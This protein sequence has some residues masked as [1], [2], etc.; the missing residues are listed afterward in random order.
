MKYL[1]WIL[2]FFKQ[3]K[4]NI[5][6]LFWVTF[7][8]PLFF[9]QSTNLDNNKIIY[10]IFYSLV[11]TIQIY[12]FSLLTYGVYKRI[13]FIL[14]FLVFFLPSIVV[15]SAIQLDKSFLKDSD[16]WFVFQ[17]NTDESIAFLGNYL[18]W[19]IGFI[20]L[21]YT[22]VSFYLL[23]IKISTGSVKIKRKSIILLPFAGFMLLSGF[24][25]S[26][27]ATNYVIDFYK[28]LYKYN[29]GLKLYD[30][31]LKDRLSKITNV[32]INLPDTLHK[33]FVVIIGES[34]DRGHM[35][36]Y[37][38]NRKTTPF[39]ES[40]ENELF[41]FNNVISSDTQTSGSLKKALTF[42]NHEFPDYYYLKPS[43][44]DLFNALRF[45]TYWIDNQFN[46]V[47]DKVPDIYVK[48]AR[49]SKAYVNLNFSKF[50]ESVLPLLKNIL[51]KKNETNKF[52]VIHLMGCHLP[53]KTRYPKSFDKFTGFDDINSVNKGILTLDQ[54]QTINEYDNSVL[55][56]DFVVSSIL[57]MVKA[58]KGF[59]Y[60]LYFSDHGEEV[61]DKEVYS[62]RSYDNITTDMCHVPFIM[63]LSD[64][65]KKQRTLHIE[66]NRPYSLENSIHT[67]IDLS[68]IKYPDYDSTR[69]L[70]SKD[71]KERIR[72][73]NGKDYS[74]LQ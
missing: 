55:Y 72:Y 34:L 18:S 26:M 56:N 62:G 22:I 39:I 58:K 46:K 53:Y 14:V 48:I 6:Y 68:F 30:D 57:N 54:K 41:V 11:F 9:F 2:N 61:Y 52:I 8:V 25:Y 66:K 31:H 3:D 17:T 59:A 49:L 50:D 71:F 63:W 74:T 60:V 13:Y 29:I 23:T 42:A 1:N 21:V 44:I 38:Y 64:D 19:G 37:G 20:V 69:S 73:V 35:S 24:S 45:R 67:V 65:Y 33:T 47:N 40:T 4:W 15:L 27:V 51:D 36:L 5:L 32:S 16:F 43:I 10:Q 7:F 28:S 70:I 12:F